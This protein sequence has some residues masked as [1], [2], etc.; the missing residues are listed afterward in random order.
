MDQQEATRPGVRVKV[1][2]PWIRL[3]HWGLV[4]LVPLSWWSGTYARWDIHF[5]SGYAILSL[6]VFRLAWGL[7]GSETARF[8]HFLR[9][10][11][12]GLRHLRHFGRRV[13]DAQIGH[14]AAGGWMVL[15]MLGLLLAQ[16]STGLFADDLILTRGPLARSVDPA[17]SDAATAVH[18]RVVWAIVAAVALHLLAIA[19]YAAVPRHDLVRPMVTGAKRLPAGAVAPR[20]AHP[21]LALALLAGAAL[22][23]WGVVRLGG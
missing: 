19:V 7:V 13:P 12:A 16:A 15:V 14:N 8:R 22:L 6:L 21:A 23:V 1:W 20:M 10:P 2:D 4:V 9:S 5:L 3:V 11:L 17:V 18:L